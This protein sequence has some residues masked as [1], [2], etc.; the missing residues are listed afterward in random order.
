LHQN[1]VKK[2]PF[3][4]IRQFQK[5][6]LDTGLQSCNFFNE[7]TDGTRPSRDYG[8]WPL[9][10]N[11]CGR[12]Q[13]F[14]FSIADGHIYRVVYCLVTGGIGTLTNAKMQFGSIICA[15]NL[16]YL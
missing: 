15:T 5:A 10:G 8:D 6:I 11:K 3:P 9:Y 16:K 14:N 13:F 2:W 1:L 12:M 4:V 7:I